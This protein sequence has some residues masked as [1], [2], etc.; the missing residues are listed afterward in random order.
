MARRRRRGESGAAIVDF[1]L[2]LMVVIPLFLAILQLAL[3]FYVRN[4]ITSAASEGARYAAAYDRGP[5]DGVARTREQIA[6]ALGGRFAAEVR[7]EPASLAGAPA[8]AIV[9]HV[10]VPA[11]GLGGPAVPLTVRATAVEEDTG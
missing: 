9:V 11:L 3:V 10:T 8:V 6:G 1:V 2:V 5:A 7:P 4:V